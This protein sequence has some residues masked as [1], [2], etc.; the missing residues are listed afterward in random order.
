[1]LFSLANDLQDALREYNA[2]P[3]SVYDEML[4]RQKAEEL[5]QIQAK[6]R[7]ELEAQERQ[8]AAREALEQRIQQELRKKSDGNDSVRYV[9][10]RSCRAF[11]DGESAGVCHEN[12]SQAV[13]HC[14]NPHSHAVH[15]ILTQWNQLT[16]HTQHRAMSLRYS[17]HTLIS[18]YD[19]F[20]VE[21]FPSAKDLK[22]KDRLKIKPAAAPP[23]IAPSAAMSA[24]PEAPSAHPSV[25]HHKPFRWKKLE[26][27]SKGVGGELYV[28][29]NLTTREKFL[30]KE[31][32]MTV[33]RKDQVRHLREGPQIYRHLHTV[34]HSGSVCH[35]LADITKLHAYSILHIFAH[36]QIAEHARV[37][38]ARVSEG[39][40]SS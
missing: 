17:T 21:D 36:R 13:K 31:I 35:T 32:V 24:S 37:A 29:H 38:R 2:K 11:S 40:V 20:G 28:A 25:P 7:R 23:A 1:M 8:L 26:R 15:C 30:L 6:A 39:A 12:S 9:T 16:S 18:S 4:M 3:V 33:S 10:E 5:A 14:W 22:E 34:M 19:L 27:I